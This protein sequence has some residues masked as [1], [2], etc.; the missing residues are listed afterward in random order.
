MTPTDVIVIGAGHNGLV[1]ACYLA[2]A[3]LD[4]EVLEAN[5]WI[6]GCTSS[7]PLVPGAPEHL[8][9]PCAQD[10]CLIR[11]SSVV[12]DLELRRHGYREVL[13]DP[14]YVAPLPDG[15]TLAFW[16]DPVST[17]AELAR[18][19]RRDARAYLRFLEMQETG[20]AAAIPYILAD[21]TRPP[22]ES[23]RA[24]I[25]AGVRHPRYMAEL[26]RMVVGS[27]AEAI[28]AR[29]RHPIVRGGLLSLAAVGAPVTHKGSGINA[30]FPAI[31]R[32]AGVSRPVGGTQT[33]PDALR[34]DLAE[35]GGRVRTGAEVTSV[36]LG[37]DRAAGVR[38]ASG[39]E[40][41]APIVISAMDPR[42][43]LAEMV[44]SGRLPDRLAARV[45]EIPSEN[46][47]AAYLTV[48]MA[49]SGELDY[50][51]M[52]RLRDDDISLRRTALLCGS[53]EEMVAAVEDCT[54][55]RM[56]APMP[57]AAVLPTG[58]DP[59]QAPPGQDTLYLWAGWAPRTPSGGW[60]AGF[61]ECAGQAMVDQAARYIDGVRELEIGRFVEPWP[62]L[63][64]RTRVPNGNPYY[65]DLL[66]ARQGPLRPALGLGGYT[67][68]IPGLFLTGGGTHP[69]PSVSGVPGQLTARKVL[70]TAPE[71]PRRARRPAATP[72][73]AEVV[74]A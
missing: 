73:P 26:A 29:F 33:L 36:L 6:G 37:G 32:H 1:A 46:G 44:P 23:I 10:F 9:N 72:A 21:P 65:V 67:T 57:F 2:R 40:L 54:S 19:D 5:D 58:P 56:P 59:S 8:I 43:T 62:L 41:R 20:M 4:V 34:A 51:R 49:L 42:R 3:G 38:I 16:R 50:S 30:M 7:A 35:H 22:L 52:E 71:L 25:G 63:E 53:F 70:A 11:L 39:E 66:M 28:D 13:V 31:V 45:A 12:R 68:P 48:H 74:R 60:D 17:A 69:G 55:G 47:G 64:Q 61:T 15:S 14:A 24:A 18:Y 27:A